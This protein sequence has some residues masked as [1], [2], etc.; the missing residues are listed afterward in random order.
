MVPASAMTIHKSQGQTVR[1]ALVC[2]LAKKMNLQ[3]Y[4]VALSRVTTQQNLYIDTRAVGT[5]DPPKTRAKDPEPYMEKM[6]LE[7]P[8]LFALEFI[9]DDAAAKFR[10]G[11]QNVN[12]ISK[13]ASYIERDRSFRCCDVLCFVET[14]ARN[15]NE[16]PLSQFRVCAH[17]ESVRN[18]QGS[19]IYVR[20]SLATHCRQL[21][22]Q[23]VRRSRRLVVEITAVELIAGDGVRVLVMNVYRYNRSKDEDVCI[24]LDQVIESGKLGDITSYDVVFV[25]GDFNTGAR[26]KFERFDELFERSMRATRIVDNETANT[27]KGNTSID[28]VY[29]RCSSKY[30]AKAT[31]F[32]SPFPEHYH[33]PIFVSLC[34]NK[35]A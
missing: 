15:R 8:Y 10:L 21:V 6:A 3:M 26:G 34:N 22:E 11:Y 23:V 18:V 9:E 31:V 32:W 16:Y 28:T 14:R 30:T 17:T 24:E 29:C 2:H 35:S 5:F 27:T 1:S 25:V 33:E 4:Y 13:Y 19:R 7:R 20:S 12:S